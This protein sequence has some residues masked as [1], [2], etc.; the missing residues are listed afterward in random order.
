MSENKN[1]ETYRIKKQVRKHVKIAHELTIKY[2][3]VFAN[4]LVSR[5][6]ESFANRHLGGLEEKQS[7]AAPRT[8]EKKHRVVHH[9]EE[10]F[11][12]D[13]KK[14]VVED[15]AA[16]NSGDYQKMNV[17][18][19][20]VYAKKE[21]GINT[22]GITKKED[23]IFLIDQYKI[24]KET[25]VSEQGDLLND[26]EINNEPKTNTDL[27]DEEETESEEETLLDIDKE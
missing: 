1:E 21:Y 23:I 18:E 16:A 22:I 11:R 24:V 9:T 27:G 25:N 5:E 26:Q 4:S 7:V 14:K 3:K 2:P 19:L 12:Y 8:T 6:L 17:D 10:S 15:V 20:K 13:D